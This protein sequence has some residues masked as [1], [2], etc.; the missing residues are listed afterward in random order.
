MHVHVHV[1][2]YNMDMYSKRHKKVNGST[3]KGS[4]STLLLLYLRSTFVHFF[5]T[6]TVHVLYMY[7]YQARSQGGGRGGRPT[8]PSR[9]PGPPGPLTDSHRRRHD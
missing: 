8:P 6:R 3:V 9:L 5:V 2:A 4:Y 1:H 7:I